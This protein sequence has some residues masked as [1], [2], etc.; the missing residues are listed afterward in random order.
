MATGRAYLLQRATKIDPGQVDV[1][2]SDVNL[3]V[4]STSLV[5]AS[6]VRQV[7]YAM[8]RLTLAGAD[9]EDLDR[10]VYD[11]YN[12]VRKGA[13]GAVGQVRFFR[14]SFAAGSGTVFA[15]TKLT[16]LTGVEYI[17]LFDASFGST[18]LDE[19]RVDVRAVQAGKASQVGR[20]AI[21]GFAQGAAL[22]DNTIQVTN[23]GATAGGEEAEDDDTLRG[24][25]R[26]FWVNASKGILSSIVQGATSVPGVASAQA[27]EV[28]TTGA[29]PARVVNLYIADSSGVANEQL[30]RQVLVALDEFRA[31]GIAVIM[32]TS[33]PLVI[34]VA[35]RLRFRA[36]VDTVQL[37]QDVLAAIVEFVNSLPVN[38]A[39]LVSD[40]MSVLRR[41]KAD[42][43]IAEDDA[44]V[45][46]AGDLE[47]AVGQ[48]LRA[49]PASVTA[50]A[51]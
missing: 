12:E 27:I 2:G 8:K 18:D 50:E 31:A 45:A 37:T 4:G 35:V 41:F 34:E 16:T 33:L 43:V 48:T 5:G 6:V 22:F 32:N 46:P 17:T 44:V 36:G 3:F 10:W 29:L 1:A 28:V 24:R 7:G 25:M 15:G 40:L 51:A 14:A 19:I 26:S 21:R 11:N 30:A 20:N 23:D 49:T 38:S 42:G 13:V 39:L 47:P 9:D